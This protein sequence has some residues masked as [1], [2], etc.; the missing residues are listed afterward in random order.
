MGRECKKCFQWKF[1]LNI[2]LPH[3]GGVSGLGFGI[4]LQAQVEHVSSVGYEVRKVECR[5]CG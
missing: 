3:L 5:L 4:D 1:E 2:K